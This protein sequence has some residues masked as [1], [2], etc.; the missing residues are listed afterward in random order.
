MPAERV[1]IVGGA[2]EGSAI[3]PLEMLQKPT[4]RRH[5]PDMGSGD[6]LSGDAPM[7]LPQVGDR[8]AAYAQPTNAQRRMGSP[9][10]QGRGQIK[11]YR[12]LEELYNYNEQHI[13]TQGFQLR[14]VRVS[15]R[16]AV[17]PDGTRIFISGILAYE[18]RLLSTAEFARKY[19]GISYEVF[20]QVPHA[21]KV[22]PDGAP[23]TS[24]VAMARLDI[25]GDPNL[26]VLP[27]AGDS[28]GGSMF[29]PSP[30]QRRAAGWQQ[31]PQQPAQ[32][33]GPDAGVVN[34]VL[35]FADR[36]RTSQQGPGMSDAAIGAI[37][38][39]SRDAATMAR[40]MSAQQVAI[41]QQQHERAMKEVENLREQLLGQR[42]EPTEFD[43]TMQM[44]SVMKASG[45]SDQVDNLMRRHSEE[46]AALERRH[47]DAVQSLE[48][49]NT[50]AMDRATKGYENELHRSEERVRE[51]QMQFDRERNALKDE[52]ERRER[53]AKS[54][55]E[56]KFSLM[57]E[58]LEN[59][60]KDLEIAHDREI[61]QLK[62][63]HDKE[64]RST[65]RLSGSE[66][67]VSEKTQGMQLSVMQ[68]EL[69]RV[70]T[71]L[72]QAKS[73]VEQSRAE[74][75]K[76]ITQQVQEI[77]ATAEALG[78]T[79]EGAAE[80]EGMGEKLFNIFSNN[81]GPILGVVGALAQ[82][83]VPSIAG[84]ATGQPAQVAAGAQPRA[85]PAQQQPQQRRQAPRMIFSEDDTPRVRTHEQ[86]VQRGVI[87]QPAPASPTAQVAPPQTPPQVEIPQEPEVVF[88]N[89]NPEP[90]PPAAP[91]AQGSQFAGMEWM[92]L[93]E[94]NLAELFN[95]LEGSYSQQKSP[96]DVA[97]EMVSQHGPDLIK[98]VL[99]TVPIDRLLSSIK[100]AQATKETAL[101]RN[102]GQKW[103]SYVWAELG[104][105]VSK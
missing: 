30:F 56:T 66:I 94:Q 95:Y 65:E 9:E 46:V 38:G 33:S 4:D 71:E 93:P 31:Q 1:D 12:T 98:V 61:R 97:G 78:M 3:T 44:M 37:A 58:Q 48:R 2:G 92:G 64:L 39:A 15:P 53:A 62:D 25:P 52:G 72:A 47:Q 29:Q 63:A 67:K 36:S 23:L 10:P 91:A 89:P 40:E 13:R 84:A 73:E 6:P 57:K 77:R 102:K 5:I 43:K 22:L 51:L 82:K 68:G 24:D 19:G 100:Q 69:N 49:S 41:L 18:N 80:K 55:V 99:N 76:P 32:Q 101:S 45:T 50:D 16:N 103:L 60:V 86:Q 74:R 7:S 83:V 85:L 70:A 59:R 105:A 27:I 20:L 88:V 42:K 35:Q 79:G 21:T 17:A 104:K 11:Q 34:A 28:S 90:P 26:E 87:R 8:G 81:P 75:L 14:V 54:E 96:A